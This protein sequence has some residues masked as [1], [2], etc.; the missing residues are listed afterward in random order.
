V[1]PPTAPLSRTP[2]VLALKLAAEKLGLITTPKKRRPVKPVKALPLLDG[3][4][5]PK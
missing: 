5:G 1:N 4:E 3:V 2:A